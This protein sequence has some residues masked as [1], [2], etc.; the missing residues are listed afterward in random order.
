MTAEPNPVKVLK[1][2]GSSFIELSDYAT[3]AK[4]L[5][6]MLT[7]ADA[8]VVVVVSGM[9]GSTGRLLDA[10]LSIDPNLQPQVQDQVLSTAEM[11]SASFM[12]AALNAAGCPATDLWAPQAGIRSD[13]AATQARIVSIDPRPLLDALSEHQVVV[14]AGG[15]AMDTGNRVTMLGRNSSDLTA[16]ALAASLSA[17]Q[18]DIFGDTP[19]ICTTDPQVVPSARLLPQL[20]YRQCIAMSESGAKVLHWGAVRYAQEHDVVIRCRRLDVALAGEDTPGTSVG[21]GPGETAV[22]GDARIRLY[23]LPPSYDITAVLGSLRDA[24]LVAHAVDHDATTMLAFPA[25]QNPER[26]LADLGLHAEPVDGFG[27]VSVIAPDGAA[28]RRL[29]DHG[30]VGSTVVA[31]HEQLYG[32]PDAED[33]TRVR[34]KPRSPHS[35][36][37]VGSSAPAAGTGSGEL[38]NVGWE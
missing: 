24:N 6:G 36:L 5:T 31:V 12:R 23:R 20:T 18:C 9:S 25:G 11:V 26:S 2:G 28:T 3:V 17:G 35:G 27:M 10:A 16:V 32:T 38:T 30:E 13:D 37:L 34:S 1:F 15:Q 22:V 7:S 4:Y 8:R 29:V 21:A 19:G 14:V 33:R